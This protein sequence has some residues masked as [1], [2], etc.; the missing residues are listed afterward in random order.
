MALGP[1]ALIWAKGPSTL[2]RQQGGRNMASSRSPLGL[3]VALVLAAPVR[4]QFCP[5]SE[6]DSVQRIVTC[7]AGVT[8]ADCRALAQTV[9]CAVVRELP[10]INAIVITEP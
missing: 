3:L 9:G 10:S 8:L 4:A 5:L 6:D 7:K 2:R 1:S